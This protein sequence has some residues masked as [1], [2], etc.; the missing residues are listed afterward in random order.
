[1]TSISGAGASRP[2]L[3]PDAADAPIATA[4]D[5]APAP[6]A[7]P[8]RGGVEKLLDRAGDAIA[9]AAGK[10][11]QKPQTLDQSFKVADGL[12]AG[13]KLTAQAFLPEADLVKNDALKASTSAALAAGGKSVA[14]EKLDGEVKLASDW[15]TPA[16]GATVGFPAGASVGWSLT[17]PFTYAQDGKLTPKETAKAAL[18]GET[19]ELPVDARRARALPAGTEFSLRG[20]LDGGISASA[21][22]ASASAGR[23]ASAQVAVTRLAGD[24]VSV[25]VTRTTTDQAGG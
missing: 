6:A 15:K 14:W 8:A 20:Q 18:L 1:M 25:A 5:A 24:Q 19:V 11:L 13:A 23:T 16:G 3:A 12:A 21:G 7:A 10:E 4:P 9:N 22:G 2:D 17:R